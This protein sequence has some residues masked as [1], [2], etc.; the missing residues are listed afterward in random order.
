MHP[1]TSELCACGGCGYDRADFSLAIVL[2]KL[3]SVGG[4]LTSAGCGKNRCLT[5]EKP[6]PKLQNVGGLVG[7]DAVRLCGRDRRFAGQ[8][9]GFSDFR[10][11]H[12]TGEGRRLCEL[13]VALRRRG[14]HARSK[15]QNFIRWGAFLGSSGWVERAKTT[16]IRV[17]SLG[18]RDGRQTVFTPDA[19]RSCRG[20]TTDRVNGTSQSRGFVLRGHLGG[21]GSCC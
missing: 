10:S 14:G 4:G 15:H 19:A 8:G 3:R 5:V 9:A 2:V 13:G 20:R 11:P 17:Y 6:W 16:S 12:V 18:G 7:A 21:V 1:W